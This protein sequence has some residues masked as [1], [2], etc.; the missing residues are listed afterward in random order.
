MKIDPPPV[1]APDK[2]RLLAPDFFNRLLTTVR[3][4]WYN[5]D[6]R[7][8]EQYAGTTASTQGASVTVAHGVDAAKIIN[9]CAVVNPSASTG[10]IPN[11]TTAGLEYTVSFDATNITI[12]NSAANSSGILLKSF[13]VFITVKK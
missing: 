3:L 8:Y 9:L 4:L 5:F 2:V 12:T 6:L 1:K 10:V 7:S 13:A 11:T